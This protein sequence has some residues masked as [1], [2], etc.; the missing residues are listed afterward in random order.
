MAC[1]GCGAFWDPAVEPAACADPTHEHH[2]FASHLHRTPVALPDGTEVVAVS[3]GG[4]DP[5]AR[6]ERT[7]FGLYL[8][9]RWDPPWPHADLDWPD[10]GVPG[11]VGPVLVAV[12]GL[13]GRA[14]AGQRVE[15]GCYG[16][17]GRTGTALAVAAVLCGEAPERAV[18]W[19]R[20][21]YCDRAVETDAQAAFVLALGS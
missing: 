10:F 4:A 8:D 12:E 9:E 1:G 11:D 20:A 17:H 5:Y 18:A 13:L 15:V 16:G 14:R 3:F 2:A 6:D 21:A 19:V 7:D